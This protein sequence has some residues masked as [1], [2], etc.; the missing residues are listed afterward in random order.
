MEDKQI[1]EIMESMNRK[2]G[3]LI[4]LQLNQQNN[5]SLKEKIYL[6]DDLA[7]DGA[8]ISSI[9]GISKVHVSKEKSLR[10]KNGR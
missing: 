1:V 9:L 5:L 4:A 10:K 7:L 8:E 3:T 6:L 2:L